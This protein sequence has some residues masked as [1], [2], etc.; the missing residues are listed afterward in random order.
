M[1]EIIGDSTEPG[2]TDVRLLKVQALLDKGDTD[3][4][5]ESA[6]AMCEAAAEDDAQAFRVRG[7][8]LAHSA[9]WSDAVADFEY[10]AHYGKL[11]GPDK[12]NYAM[13]LSQ[14]SQEQQRAGDLESAI[15]TMERSLEVQEHARRRVVLASFLAAADRH[16]DA[17]KAVEPVALADK[18]DSE[19][20]RVYGVSLMK[21]ERPYDASRALEHSFNA[22]TAALSSEGGEEDDASKDHRKNLALNA[23]VGAF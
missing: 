14:Q 1:D 21:V 6:N 20:Q 4:A 15:A 16:A 7:M 11:E 8:V 3:S 19:A 23:G 18:S 2:Q 17:V 10:A 9:R 5:L 12:Q 22:L 13:C